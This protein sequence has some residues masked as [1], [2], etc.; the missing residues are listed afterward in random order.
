M[1]RTVY[2]SMPSDVYPH[3]ETCGTNGTYVDAGSRP[4]ASPHAMRGA[5]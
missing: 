2:S 1:S 5:V 4:R 3:M